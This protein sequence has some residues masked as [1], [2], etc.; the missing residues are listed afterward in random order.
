MFGFSKRLIEPEMLEHAEPADARVNL[1][2]LVVLN[3]RFGGHST[4]RKLFR[5]A[6]LTHE[7]FTLLDVGA[8]SGDSGQLI[9]ELCPHAQVTNF[10]CSALNLTNAP[11]PKVVGDAFMMPFAPGAFDYVFC[12]LFLHHFTDGAIADL[13]RQFGSIARR[14][15]LVCDL[16]R[17]VLPYL[18]MALSQ[19]VFRWHRITV[20]D[21]KKS[22]RAALSAPELLRLAQAAGLP[23][24][25]VRVNR[26]AFRLT[27]VAKTSND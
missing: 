17:N 22:F 10:D 20:H 27:L 19:P 11:Y 7:S 24:P 15:V 3:K 1:R 23:N 26:P 18:F 14:G 9:G 13:L 2:E 16:E 8:A 4:I 21:G 5:E 12:S 25:S 6:A